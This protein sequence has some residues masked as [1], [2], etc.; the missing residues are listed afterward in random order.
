[1][2]ARP[3][4]RVAGRSLRARR[5]VGHQFAGEKFD[6]FA[7]FGFDSDPQHSF[8]KS[9]AGGCAWVNRTDAATETFDDAVSQC[10]TGVANSLQ[11]QFADATRLGLRIVVR[12]SSVFRLTESRRETWHLPYKC[13]GAV[14]QLRRLLERDR[15][16][17]LPPPA[18]GTRLLHPD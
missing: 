18:S 9:F 4:F 7:R 16:R 14:C 3:A 6:R 11:N 2:H 17:D 13:S 12:R 5:D 15:C 8:A 1:M 10:E